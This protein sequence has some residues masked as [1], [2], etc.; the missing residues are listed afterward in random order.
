MRN[1]HFKKENLVTAAQRQSAMW[2]KLDKVKCV[3]IEEGGLAHS[4]GDYDSVALLLL[5][6]G[7][8]FRQK[9]NPY[10]VTI[11]TRS[12]ND[13]ALAYTAGVHK[14]GLP[15]HQYPFPFQPV[16]FPPEGSDFISH[17]FELHLLTPTAERIEQAF[18]E[19]VVQAMPAQAVVMY[20]P[21]SFSPSGYTMDEWVELIL[22]KVSRPDIIKVFV[23]GFLG[24]R[25]VFHND[26][27]L[28][29]E[30]GVKGLHLGLGV[31]DIQ[32]GL[33]L[34]SILTGMPIEKSTISKV[35]G[36]ALFT[37][38]NLSLPRPLVISVYGDKDLCRMQLLFAIYK[39][40]FSV[41]H[42]KELFQWIF[43]VLN[44]KGEVVPSKA[45]SEIIQS[46]EEFYQQ[47]IQHS[48]KELHQLLIDVEGVP[49]EKAVVLP[50]SQRDAL[51]SWRVKDMSRI[52]MLTKNLFFDSLGQGRVDRPF[53]ERSIQGWKSE[54][55]KVFATRNPA[56]GAAVAASMEAQR[57]GVVE[58]PFSLIPDNVTYEGLNTAVH[59]DRR[60]S[61]EQMKKL[62]Q[63]IKKLIEEVKPI[64]QLPLK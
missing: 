26:F 10:L 16:A 42:G 56:A 27:P 41:L 60:L 9:E 8:V 21:K 15:L 36:A 34:A 53:L 45:L 3:S 11:L 24:A 13:E 44:E 63:R 47:Q 1:D 46:A 55:Q 62:P 35:A 52:F 14:R 30:E 64:R 17:K 54:I 50:L 22:K 37:F 12:G 28:L 7:M 58:D 18:H 57:Y 5:I 31:S 33:R 2:Q 6:Q 25:A 32:K 39:N 51:E 59:L 38:K 48:L 20:S 43:K 49:I 40:V 61:P 23:S 29:Q 19:E 4:G